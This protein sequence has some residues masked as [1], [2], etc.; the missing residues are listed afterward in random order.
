MEIIAYHQ[1]VHTDPFKQYYPDEFFRGQ[2]GKMVIE[3]QAHNPLDAAT[4]QGFHLFP[5][6][7]QTRRRGFGLEKFAGMRLEGN[8][9]C[10]HVQICR[11]FRQLAEH[12]LMAQ[13]HTIEA[14]D[15]GGATAMRGPQIV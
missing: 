3:T 13:M 14:A 1:V 15:R 10:R 7:R 6:T 11:A 12:G 4:P 5:E 2:T 9:R 8:Q